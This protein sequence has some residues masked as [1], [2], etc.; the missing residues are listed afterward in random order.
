MKVTVSS[1]NQIVVPKEVRRQ[2]GIKPGDRLEFTHGK[3][4]ASLKKAPSIREEL[5]K[6]MKM[7]PPSHTNAVERVRKLR[8]EW[9]Q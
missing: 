8:D 9:E 7:S 5:D 1:K 4:S 6:I 3:T 2:L